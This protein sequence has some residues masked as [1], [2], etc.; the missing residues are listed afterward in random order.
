MT[1][2][3][4][5]A[6]AFVTA[7]VLAT[8]MLLCGLAQARKHQP[9]PQSRLFPTTGSL[10]LQNA[11]A[12]RLRLPRIQ[13]NAEL[14]ELINDGELAP[15]VQTRTLRVHIPNERAYLRPWA[16]FTLYLLSMDFYTAFGTPLQVNSA[17]RT[18]KFQKHL[19]RWNH[20]AA[21]ATGEM[22]S[23][24]TTGIAFDLQTRGLTAQQHY[25]LEWRLFYMQETGQALVEEEFREPC[26]HV[27]SIQQ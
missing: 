21:P 15:L 9:L 19:G 16:A 22:A 7:G 14:H 24:H 5:R 2:R 20:N 23:V 17:V 8:V 11:E 4:A 3:A 10:Q 25:W 27:V 18:V 26:F 1:W 6:S 12:N 13:N